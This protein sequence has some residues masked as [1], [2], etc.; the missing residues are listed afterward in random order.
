MK[1]KL[2]RK[3]YWLLV[4]LFL[5]AS[6]VS[7]ALVSQ[8]ATPSG[9][10]T[11]QPA[12]NQ[13]QEATSLGEVLSH[14]TQVTHLVTK[15][16]DGDTLEVE[17]GKKVRLIGVDT[18]ETGECYFTEAKSRLSALILNK[19]IVLEK[20]TSEVDRYQRLLRYVYLEGEFING[21][22]VAEGYARAVR[23][24]PDVL[25]SEQLERLE[26][27]AKQ[28]GKGLWKV[29]DH[30]TPTSNPTTDTNSVVPGGSSFKPVG[31]S[32]KSADFTSK[33]MGSD[34]DCVIKGNISQSTDEKIYHTPGQRDYEK[35]VI[36]ESKGERYFCSE[37]EAVDAGWRKAK[38]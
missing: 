37:Q 17:G 38:R 10:V 29:C 20:D 4:G 24:P 23:Y 34:T 2:D 1:I 8:Q 19:E 22:L 12:T 14:N 26:A 28:Q 11:P 3:N 18:P 30:P 36:D 31:S 33:P 16:V 21:V 35:T 25:L 27:E 15:V 7:Q 9:E 13:E 5:V 6:W 32:P